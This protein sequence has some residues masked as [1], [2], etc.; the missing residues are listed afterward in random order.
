MSDPFAR[1]LESQRLAADPDASV[2]VTANAGSG[3]TKVLIDRVARLLLRGDPPSSFLCIT[4]TKAAAAEMQRRLFERLGAWCTMGNDD[5]TRELRALDGAGADVSDAALSR[6][7]AL[8]AHALETPGGLRIQT[9]HAFCERLLRRFPLEAE[10]AP[11]F[12][13]IDEG[14]A[15]ALMASAWAEIVA[16]PDARRALAHLARRLDEE[17]LENLM[18]GVNRRRRV[19]RA[20]R[21]GGELPEA[22]ARLRSRHGAEADREAF[23]AAFFAGTPWR[24]LDAAIDVLRGGSK[25]DGDAAAR[26][27]AARAAPGV[28]EAYTAIFMTQE[29]KPRQSLMT[30]PLR[31][32]HGALDASLA[33]EQARVVAA[34]GALKAIDRA[35]DAV[36]LMIL[37]DYLLG[38][39]AKA[40]AATGALDFEDLIERAEALLTRTGAAPWVLFK[41]DGG[42]DHI[43]IDEGQDTSPAQWALLEP[44]QRE[45]FAGAGARVKVR[46]VFAVGDPKQSIYS[47]QGADSARFLAQAQT[48]SMRAAGAE[49]RFHAPDMTMSFRST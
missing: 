31:R 40:K 15:E 18:A 33:Q 26:I 27:H 19:L 12:E 37:G 41:L 7:R 10:T 32:A 9:I 25:T 13:V 43:L 4:Y 44:L 17:A 23:L 16:A 2:F 49:L 11:G 21:Q 24:D 45:F 3:K 20:M 29:R 48:L 8:F 35:D 28:F 22:L 39:Y 14:Q 46:T 5:L 1:A 30:A 34:I 36:A 42:I 38:A 47:F 6:A